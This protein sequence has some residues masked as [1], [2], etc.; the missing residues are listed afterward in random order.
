MKFKVGD[1]VTSFEDEYEE[2]GIV[3]EIDESDISEPYCVYT[4][5]G[6]ISQFG[7]KNQS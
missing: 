7:V 5:T 4:F 6:M 2:N 1:I 3:V